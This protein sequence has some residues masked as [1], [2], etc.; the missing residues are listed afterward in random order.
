MFRTYLDESGIHE[1]AHTCAVAGYSG[2]SAAWKTFER[3]WRRLLRDHGVHE[4]HAQKFWTFQRGGSGR[5]ASPY[6]AWSQAKAERF[7]AEAFSIIQ[8]SRIA[9][10]ASLVLLEDWKELTRKQRQF[11]AGGDYDAVDH[12]IKSPAPEKGF[13]LALLGCIWSAVGHSR[14]GE[15]VHFVLDQNNQLSGYAVNLF[16]KLKN[17]AVTRIR[18]RLGSITFA[19]SEDACPIQAADILAYHLIQDSPKMRQQN[20]V[21][22]PNDV[23]EQLLSGVR[24]KHDLQLYDKKGATDITWGYF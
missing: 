2:N 23:L 11:L 16:Q 1:Q 20:T 4:F 5:R 17:G 19:S 7:Q 9:P 13:Y 22:V 10:V 21:R 15:R 12:A 18:Q 3:R 14:T 24:S 8:D 6:S